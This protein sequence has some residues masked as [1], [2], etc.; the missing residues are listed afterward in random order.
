MVVRAAERVSAEAGHDRFGPDRLDRRGPTGTLTVKVAPGS[1]SITRGG[2]VNLLYNGQVL[3]SGT[4]QVVNGVDEVS[5]TVEFY[6]QGT[7]SF[8]AQYAGSTTVPV[9]FQQYHL[10]DRVTLCPR[11]GGWGRDS[12]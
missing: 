12:G 7:F 6:G 9:E 8:A 11:L 5:F 10:R 4:L 2:K 3:G 1:G